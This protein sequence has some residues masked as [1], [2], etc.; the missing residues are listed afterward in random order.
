MTLFWKKP[1]LFWRRNEQ[2]NSALWATT[3]SPP[4]KSRN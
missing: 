2:S 1:S 3:T 4:T